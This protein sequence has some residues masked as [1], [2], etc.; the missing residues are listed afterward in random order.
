MEK[1]ADSDFKR[2]IGVWKTSGTVKS[3]QGDLTLSGIDSY[4]LVLD[5]NFILHKADVKMGNEHSE[6]VE[7]IHSA[8][9]L[10]QATMQYFNSRG[11]DGKMT[12]SIID[13]EFTI[14]GNGLKFKGTIDKHDTLVIGKWYSK[15]ESE[16]WNEFIELK[17]ERQH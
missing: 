8:G 4:E 11:E 5:G 7:M 10:D 1:I 12:S 15:G 13:N 17:L 9:S 6:T 3:D 2:L 16:T 14:I